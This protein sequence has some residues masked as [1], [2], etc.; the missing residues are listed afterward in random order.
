MEFACTQAHW[1]SNLFRRYAVP[2]DVS[3]HNERWFVSCPLF[4]DDRETGH[5]V[6]ELVDAALRAGVAR[7]LQAVCHWLNH[8]RAFNAHPE[9]WHLMWSIIKD[10][11]VPNEPYSWPTVSK[12]IGE[13]IFGQAH[14][15]GNPLSVF[16]PG[17]VRLSSG[18]SPIA[19]ALGLIGV[20]FLVS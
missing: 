3:G 10:S 7:P 18:Q 20:G 8:R 19:T 14:A 17:R 9:T 15:N 13:A 5:L 4:A 16:G 11:L 1:L 12:R 2:H 6:I